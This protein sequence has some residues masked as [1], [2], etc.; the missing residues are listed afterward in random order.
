M[1][2][3]SKDK[4]DAPKEAKGKGGKL[5]WIIIGLVLLVGLGGG[6]FFAWQKFLKPKFFPPKVE[7]T[8]EGEGHG[9]AAKDS[10]DAKDAKGGHGES[11]G[12]HGD[13]KGKGGKPGEAKAEAE[14]LVSMPPFVVNLA[15]PLGRRYLKLALDVE[16]K[17]K[18]AAQELTTKA[19]KARDSVILLLSSKTYQDLSSMEAK[20]LLKKEIAERLNQSLGGARVQRVYITEM[21]VQ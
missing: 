13:A 19:A 11:K 18:E 17:D 2:D 20:I 3:A 16:V 7:E 6:G 14:V 4:K 12:G 9:E 10:K 5:K 21:V 1:A 8:A 15:D